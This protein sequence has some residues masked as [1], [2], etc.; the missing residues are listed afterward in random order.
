VSHIDF[1][2]PVC[3]IEHFLN[4]FSWTPVVYL[5]REE[6]KRILKDGDAV[7][8]EKLDAYEKCMY[9]GNH[10][11]AALMA[12]DILSETNQIPCYMGIISDIQEERIHN[13]QADGKLNDD[14]TVVN[15]WGLL[16]EA[17]MFLS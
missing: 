9:R 16:Q 1:R 2:N 4:D 15:V 8:K 17:K 6:R 7:D 12:L 11:S 13:I 10:L 14:Q 3:V 5:D